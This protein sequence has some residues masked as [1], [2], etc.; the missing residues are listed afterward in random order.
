MP[1]FTARDRIAIAVLGALILVGWGARLVRFRTAPDDGVRVIRDA[2]TTPAAPSAVSRAAWPSSA[3]IDLN[4]ATAAELETLPG[5]G[6]KRAADIVRWRAEH[7]P[8]RQ[9]RDLMNVGGIG[10]KTYDRIAPYIT[11]IGVPE[12]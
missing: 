2:V 12:R 6:P 11:V 9:P 3:R 8:F 4:H 1:L 5:I 10:R 7:G